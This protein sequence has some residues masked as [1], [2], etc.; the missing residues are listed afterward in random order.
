[1]DPELPRFFWLAGQG[2]FGIMTSSAAARAAAALIAEDSLPGDLA[3]LGV[4]REQLSPA[5]LAG[6][7]AGG[8]PERAAEC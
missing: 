3:A 7:G 1:M 6:K 2:G 5:R 4:T 8:E